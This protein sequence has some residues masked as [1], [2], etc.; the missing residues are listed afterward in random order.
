VPIVYVLPRRRRQGLPPDERIKID[1]AP[2]YL[3]LHWC[4]PPVNGVEFTQLDS[5]D[6]RGLSAMIYR[7]MA[8]DRIRYIPGATGAGRRR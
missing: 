5:Y 7:C 6:I 3:A 8:H 1:V 4:P 2:N